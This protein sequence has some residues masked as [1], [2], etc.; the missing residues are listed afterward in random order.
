MLSKRQ[1]IKGKWKRYIRKDNKSIMESNI[2][3][4]TYTKGIFVL[5]FSETSRN[6]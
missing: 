6:Y 4:I 2:H 3:P 5:W 1:Q